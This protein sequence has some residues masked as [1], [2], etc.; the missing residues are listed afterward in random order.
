MRRP[1]EILAAGLVL[2]ELTMYAG[3]KGAWAAAGLAAVCFAVLIFLSG[4]RGPR[5]LSRRQPLLGTGQRKRCRAVTLL[6]ALGFLLGAL[7]LYQAQR[8]SPEERSLDLLTGGST[9]ELTLTCRAEQLLP[10]RDG[11]VH[12]RS[13]LL[14]ISCPEELVDMY[15]KLDAIAF[16]CDP[17]WY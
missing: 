12:V 17:L 15:K 1:F 7:R 9:A 13:G 16:L 5:V 6:L 4:E 3:S 2:G 10:G 14:L 8:I 11:R